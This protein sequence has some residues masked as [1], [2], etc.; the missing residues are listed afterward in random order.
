MHKHLVPDEIFVSLK[1]CHKYRYPHLLDSWQLTFSQFIIFL[2]IYFVFVHMN[3]EGN[4]KS[5]IREQPTT[6]Q[7]ERQQKL[8]I[9]GLKK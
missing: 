5:L 2:H 7:F 6:L 4:A 9:T 8:F 1:V 3:K